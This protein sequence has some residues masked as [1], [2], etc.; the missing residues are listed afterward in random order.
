MGIGPH[1]AAPPRTPA[2]PTEPPSPSTTCSPASS[3]PQTATACRSR[4]RRMLSGASATDAHAAATTQ[5]VEP[6]AA[7]AP[8][9]ATRGSSTAP[10][11]PQ[12]GAERAAAALGGRARQQSLLARK[13]RNRCGRARAPP[14]RVA[15][16]HLRRFTV[17]GG[18]CI[19]LLGR[20]NR[21]LS[22]SSR[23]RRTGT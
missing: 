2:P 4:S 17:R 19:R 16:S 18:A 23:R 8:R 11:E 21:Q 22:R 12:R 5:R 7:P 6:P 20:T 3:S 13:P 14:G 10:R 1:S 15:S 9:S